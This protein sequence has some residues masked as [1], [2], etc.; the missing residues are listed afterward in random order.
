MAEII[1]VLATTLVKFNVH[2]DT[3]KIMSNRN[4]MASTIIT[5]LVW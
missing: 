3:V 1:W 2:L 5:I 4:I